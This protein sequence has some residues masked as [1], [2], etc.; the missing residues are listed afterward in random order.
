MPVGHD[1]R[2]R[3]WVVVGCLGYWRAGAGALVFSK[4][5]PDLLSGIGRWLFSLGALPKTLV[6]DREGS[7]HAGGGRPHRGLLS[8]SAAG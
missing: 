8:P 4:Q 1:E 5:A 2:R 3:A 6:W 7:I